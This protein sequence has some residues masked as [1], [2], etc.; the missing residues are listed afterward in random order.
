MKDADFEEEM[1]DMIDIEE[2]ESFVN[3]EELLEEDEI[4][5]I[6]EAFLRGYKAA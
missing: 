2:D 5:A 4:D 1:I 6:T 3:E